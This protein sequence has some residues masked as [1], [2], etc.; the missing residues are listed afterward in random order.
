MIKILSVLLTLSFTLCSADCF[1]QTDMVNV[2][3]NIQKSKDILSSVFDSKKCAADTPQFV[4]AVKIGDVATIKKMLSN[5]ADIYMTDSDG[6]TALVIAVMDISNL[7]VIDTMLDAEI[8]KKGSI[9]P[10]TFAAAI[11]S[12]NTGFSQEFIV[13]KLIEKGADVN[14][15]TK[16]GFTPLMIAA[17]GQNINMVNLLVNAGAD[18][19]AIVKKGEYLEVS[20]NDF[21]EEYAKQ[22]ELYNF[23]NDF[24]GK[25]S[26]LSIAVEINLNEE[27]AVITDILYKKGAIV[28]YKEFTGICLYR[29]SDINNPSKKMSVTSDDEINKLLRTHEIKY[30]EYLGKCKI[31]IDAGFVT[32]SENNTYRPANDEIKNYWKIDG[33]I[34]LVS[35]HGHKH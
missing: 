4:C 2:M 5:G 32:V 21:S 12:G 30:D 28:D 35:E 20:A 23:M 33:E 25:L 19:N 22:R 29:L 26:P 3:K 14:G 18:I 31:L 15:R 13:K 1:A 34:G 24:T 16:F 7:E 9:S 8:K 17:F 10:D 27:S 6:R 11:S